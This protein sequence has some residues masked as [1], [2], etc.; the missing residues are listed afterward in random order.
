M[1]MRLPV[2]FRKPRRAPRKMRRPP[3]I[4]A[5]ALEPLEPR[6]LLSSL[7][8]AIDYTLDTLNFFDTQEK[9]DLLQFAADTIVRRFDDTLSAII[10]SGGNTWDAIF[11]NPATGGQESIPN[12][13]V[14]ANEIIVFAGGRNLGGT[15]GQGGSGG[16]SAS[17]SGAWPTTVRTRGETGAAATPATDF[18]PWGGAVTFNTTTNWHFGASEMGL[19]SGESDFLSVAFHEMAHLLGFSNAV[20]SFERYVDS[21]NDEFTGPAAVAEYDGAGNPPLSGDLS[22]WEAGLMDEGL[23]TAMDPAITVGTRKLFTPLDF[24]AFDDLGWELNDGTPLVSIND[25]QVTEGNAG[26][27]DLTFTV[28]LSFASEDDVM[29]DFA[30]AHSTTDG[31]DYT[32]VNG[33]LTIPAGQTTGQVTVQ[34]NGDNTVENDETFFVNLSGIV[35]GRAD[36]LQGVGTVLNDDIPPPT[37]RV[38]ATDA[39]GSETGPNTL[40]FTFSRT[41]STASSITLNLTIGGT[42]TNGGDY[43]TVADTLVIPAGQSSVVLTVTPIDDPFVEGSETVIFTIDA[44]PLYVLGSP[45]STTGN[46]ADDDVPPTVTVTATDNAASETG[47]DTATFTFSRTGPTTLQVTLNL[48]ITGTAVNGTDYNALGTTLVIPAG[49]S[50]ATL[51]VTPIDDALD[52]GGET[53]IVSIL[54][55][56][57]YTLGSPIS[58]TANIIDNDDLTGPVIADLRFVLV[59]NKPTGLVLSFNEDLAAATAQ[60]TANYSFMLAGKDKKPG[61]ADDIP[62][63]LASAVYNSTDDTVTLT[64]TNTKALKLNQFMRGQVT[65]GI[66]DLSGNPLT[67]ITEANFAIGTSIK[68]TDSQ[69]DSVSLSLKKGGLMRFFIGDDMD[70][71][72]LDVLSAVPGVSVLSGKVKRGKASPPAD[73]V[74]T[75]DVLGS[76]SGAVNM[77]PSQFVIG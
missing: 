68:Y 17:G 19:D 71:V 43:N 61:T 31:T 37:V 40:A 18:G 32:P 28:S 29:V 67:G 39:S 42:A 66:T 59:K 48:S 63:P 77:L 6:L 34:V 52:E 10:P 20:D 27:T 58:A 45:A 54:S 13:T 14:D 7:F 41:G 53:V 44:D 64:P 2:P 5:A 74:A 16:F 21:V 12:M 47:P 8:V 70:G 50:S 72:Q 4:P 33:T 30:T 75:L 25:A 73:G 23:E 1:V 51:T 9:K 36:G 56:A 15:L 11:P 24:A 46:I 38:Q 3:C 69:G 60:N 76:L 55:D 57:S 49:Q 65:Q 35:N 22:H 26:T 62:A